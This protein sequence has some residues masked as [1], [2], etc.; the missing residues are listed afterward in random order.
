LL[1]AVA[2]KYVPGFAAE[3]GKSH[4]SGPKKIGDR[5]NTMSH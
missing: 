5:F 4:K 3:V 1:A 2:N